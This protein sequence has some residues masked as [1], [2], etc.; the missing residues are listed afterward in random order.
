MS[1]QNVVWP[2]SLLGI[3]AVAL[4]FIFVI[5][6]AQRPA[7]AGETLRS[8]HTAHVFQAWFFGLM[9]VGFAAGT[10][11]TLRHFPI[12]N[13]HAPLQADL[14]VNVESSMWRWNIDNKEP[15]QAG[16]TVEFRVTSK[17]V[18]HDFAI[19]GPDGNLVA[20]TQAMPGF[21]NKLLY[22]F[23]EPGTYTVQCLEYCGVGHGH[24]RITI[25]VEA[26]GK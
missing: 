5:S 9:L 7:T 13:Q 12:P 25:T 11:L 8:A 21:T 19:Y 14:V 23:E 26:A 2:L 3:T 4:V 1:I 15:I 18:N 10:W 24:M 16:Q 6:Q 20:Q 22:Q 17:D